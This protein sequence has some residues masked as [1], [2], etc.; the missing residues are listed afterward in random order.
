MVVT[1]DMDGGAWSV[2]GAAAL[3]GVEL[4]TAYNVGG[5]WTG[6]VEVDAAAMHN[7]SS[8]GWYDSAVVERPR[9]VWDS[10]TP[11]PSR[12]WVKGV[13][14]IR[15]G[16]WWG[17][18]VALVVMVM[19]TLRSCVKLASTLSDDCELRQ[20]GGEMARTITATSCRRRQ[21]NSRWLRTHLE[22]GRSSAGGGARGRTRA[23]SAAHWLAVGWDVG[24]DREAEEE[25]EKEEE[26][27]EEVRTGAGNII[28]TTSSAATAA[29]AAAAGA[30]TAATTK[31][32]VVNATLT[33]QCG[34][35]TNGGGLDDDDGDEEEDDGVGDGDCDGDGDG[36]GQGEGG[37][38][39][40]VVEA[41]DGRVV[42][43]GDSLDGPQLRPH[44]ETMVWP[45]RYSAFSK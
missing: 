3:Q 12:W 28:F 9:F 33:K 18:H 23:S 1:M 44:G 26:E 10:S 35:E 40:D 5:D 29:T 21:L 8:D 14:E 32:K 11:Q 31:A 38:H 17:K 13:E 34:A 30:Q 42:S 20:G 41:H 39:M 19:E 15:H 6:P 36:D 7:V 24:S 2:D 22:D 37:L 43:L 25:E 16:R 27:E 45:C 4:N